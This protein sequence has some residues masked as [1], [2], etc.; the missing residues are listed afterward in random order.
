MVAAARPE[1]MTEPLPATGTGSIDRAGLEQVLALARARD[2]VVLGPG[3]G[4]DPSSR[5]LARELVRRCPVPLVV[6]A[7]G[8]NALAP[9]GRAPAAVEALSREAATVVTPHPGEMARLTGSSTAEVQ[10]RRLETARAFATRTGAVV[11]LKGQRTIVAEATGR[12]A[13]NPTGN[14][15]MAT[16]GTGDVLSG[17][18]GALLARGLD[19]WGASAA[20]TYVHGL[21]GDAAAADRGEESMVAGDLVA[22]LPRAILRLAAGSR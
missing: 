11:V 15:G 21:A 5:E 4:Q 18:L 8:L 2:A 20:G 19:A 10:R 7:D 1:L 6:D 3:L 12:A 22:A 16:G 9:A 14:P 17:I 13:V